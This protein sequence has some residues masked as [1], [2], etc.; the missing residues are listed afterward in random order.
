MCVG[1]AQ[2]SLDQLATQEVVAIPVQQVTLAVGDIQA[3][4]D[5]QEVQ[6]IQ[7]VLDTPVQPAQ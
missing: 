3:Q 5:I 6:D 4:L 2:D 7:A 1:T